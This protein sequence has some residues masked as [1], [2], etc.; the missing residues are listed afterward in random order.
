MKNKKAIASILMVFFLIVQVLFSGCTSQRVWTY[1]PEGKIELEPLLDKSVAVPPLIDE[2][3]NMNL[4][5]SGLG[6]IPFFPYGWQTMYTPEGGQEHR[7]S[8]FWL[9]IPTEDF[10]KAIAIELQNSSLFEQVFFTHRPSEADL[11]LK[12]TIE[13]TQYTSKMYTYCFSLMGVYLWLF[14]F[15]SGSASNELILDLKLVDN[16]TDQI[17]WESRY[18]KS[19]RSTSWIYALNSDFFY[20]TML[21]EIME[22][23]IASLKKSLN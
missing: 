15:P 7:A 19:A 22:E 11:S 2:R 17:I 23:V 6:L 9:F 8:G 13:S 5:R 16:T 12:G 21:K 4:N 1:S 20:D 3:V 14:G 18:K 10:A